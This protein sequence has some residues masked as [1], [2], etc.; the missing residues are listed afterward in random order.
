MLLIGDN[1][2]FLRQYLRIVPE[3]IGNLLCAFHFLI[4]VFTRACRESDFAFLPKLF[5][6]VFTVFYCLLLNFSS[7]IVRTEQNKMVISLRTCKHVI[8][9]MV[10]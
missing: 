4:A 1:A 6:P 7:L 8:I 3:D 10:R 5:L 2:E 9:D